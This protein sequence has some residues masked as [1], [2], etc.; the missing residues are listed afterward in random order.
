MEHWFYAGAPLSP[1]TQ[2]PERKMW[3]K[4]KM[5]HGS[6]WGLLFW[7]FLD[8]FP[9]NIQDLNWNGGGGGVLQCPTAAVK[10]YN[11]TDRTVG[12]ETGSF[13]HSRDNR[14]NGSY[15]KVYAATAVN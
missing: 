4:I 6:G 11:E 5:N 10:Q 1:V 2:K 3:N 13:L 12:Y 7:S 8:W 14:D 9:G 15:V